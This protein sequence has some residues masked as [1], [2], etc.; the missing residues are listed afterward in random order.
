M[1]AMAVSYTERVEA[2]LWVLEK[3]H[4]SCDTCGRERGDRSR[5]A[6][7]NIKMVVGHVDNDL[8]NIRFGNLVAICDDC[9][10]IAN[11]GVQIEF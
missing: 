3:A 6:R 8:E 1:Q 9:L 2:Y 11:G 10:R 4:Y 7:R 5:F